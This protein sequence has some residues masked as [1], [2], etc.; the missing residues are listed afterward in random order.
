VAKSASATS[1]KRG[2][3]VSSWV[4]FA[5]SEVTKQLAAP[6][7]MTISAAVHVFIY[8]IF[9][10]L[11]VRRIVLPSDHESRLGESRTVQH[12]GTADGVLLTQTVFTLGRRE[13]VERGLGVIRV[14]EETHLI[15]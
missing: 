2:R 9:I 12:K 3:A 8:I 4:A 10:R 6:I 15:C 11:T 5:P 7:D 14:M 13:E 1:G